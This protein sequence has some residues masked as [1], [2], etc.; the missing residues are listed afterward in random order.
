[1]C[2]ICVEFLPL[3]YIWV[4][5]TISHSVV[6]S[7]SLL[8]VPSFKTQKFY[9][10]IKSRCLI[11]FGRQAKKSLQNLRSWKLTLMDLLRVLSLTFRFLIYFSYSFIFEMGAS[12]TSFLC[13]W[14]S[15]C[16]RNIY[17]KLYPCS[18]ELKL[19]SHSHWKA[20]DLGLFVMHRFILDPWLYSI[21]C[22]M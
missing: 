21:H 1:M 3:L 12:P 14:I 11:A 19:F 22:S 9:I 16:P 7:F 15:S 6:R 18:T 4:I 20:I 10:C 17:W 2:F 8:I 13:M 5:S